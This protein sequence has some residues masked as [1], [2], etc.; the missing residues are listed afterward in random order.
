MRRSER[1]V[2]GS[3]GVTAK[4]FLNACCFFN[5]DPNLLSSVLID[6]SS[7]FAAAYVVEKAPFDLGDPM[8]GISPV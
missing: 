5:I 7:V 2:A 8:S 3:A 1:I 4:R 6:D